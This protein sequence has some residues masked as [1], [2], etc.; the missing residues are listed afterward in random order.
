MKPVRQMLHIPADPSGQRTILIVLVHRG[1][2]A[3]LGISA[4]YLRDARFEVDAEPLP[5]QKEETGV[6]WRP[7]WAPPWAGSRGGKEKRDE[8]SFRQPTVGLG[9]RTI[10]CT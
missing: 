7:N 6:Y 10:L 2:I 8:S 1:Q 9:G 3:P 4:S 5:L